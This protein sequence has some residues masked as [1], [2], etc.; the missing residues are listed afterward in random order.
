MKVHAVDEDGMANSFEIDRPP[1]F[2]PVCKRGCNPV[3]VSAFYPSIPQYIQIV[4]RCTFRNCLGIFVARYGVQGSSFSDEFK[5]LTTEILRFS[6]R[7]VFNKS[8][9]EISPDFCNIYWE[10]VTAEANDLRLVCG[11]GYR[12]SLEFLI[13]DFIIKHILKEK[14]SEHERVKKMFLAKCIDIYI[15]DLRIKEVAKRA[16]WL[17]N[18]ET[19]YYRHWPDKDLNDLKKLIDM[20]IN[21]IELVI[22]SETLLEDMPEG[23]K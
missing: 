21:W 20:T 7:R 18:D 2:C 16:V 1:D 9:V 17:G 10:S 3:K 14:A 23:K 12:K 6:E 15:N 8:I 4:Y 5:L 22:D 11:V 19:H 13:K